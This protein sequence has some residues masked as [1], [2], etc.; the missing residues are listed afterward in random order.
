MIQTLVPLVVM[1][2]SSL[3]HDII[4]MANPA[5]VPVQGSSLMYML[6]DRTGLVLG[7]SEKFPHCLRRLLKLPVDIRRGRFNP[8]HGVWN[9]FQVFLFYDVKSPVLIQGSSKISFSTHNT[10]QFDLPFP[11]RFL[12]QYS[13]WFDVIVTVDLYFPDEKDAI[14]V[15]KGS[16]IDPGMLRQRYL[17]LGDLLIG[18]HP[19][20][21]S[22]FGCILICKRR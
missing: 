6:D 16:G 15:M 18:W 3:T 11:I 4:L 20:D 12:Y 5:L 2:A 21:R 9:C 10:L 19:V 7:F 1:W 17:C 22:P 14:E 8:I 13:N